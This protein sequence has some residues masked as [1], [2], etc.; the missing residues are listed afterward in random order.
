LPFLRIASTAI[1]SAD[2][3]PAPIAA[4]IEGTSPNEAPL[5]SAKIP[6]L[7]TTSPII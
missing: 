4:A 3:S 2:S 1:A 5:T 7:H 6:I